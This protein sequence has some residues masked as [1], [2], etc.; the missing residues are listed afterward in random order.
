MPSIVLPLP[1]D[2]IEVTIGP[3]S[4]KPPEGKRADEHAKRTYISETAEIDA[5]PAYVRAGAQ[6]PKKLGATR[7]VHVPKLDGNVC[8]AACHLE[9]W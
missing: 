9:F 4:P 8:H 5:V 7:D 1:A 3:G 2:D 6:L